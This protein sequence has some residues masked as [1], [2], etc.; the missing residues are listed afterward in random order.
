M[1]ESQQQRKGFLGTIQRIICR[2]V[3][4]ETPP[5]PTP[6]RDPLRSFEPGRVIILAEFPPELKL[7]PQEIV[8]RV[9]RRLDQVNLEQ[10]EEVRLPPER[11]VIL[12][13]PKLWLASVQGDV[14]A[15]R[16]DPARLFRFIDGL[17]QAIKKPPLETKPLGQDSEPQPPE[18]PPAPGG[19]P[20]QPGGGSG[21]QPPGPGPVAAARAITADADGFDL[22]A[23]SPNWFASGSKNIIGGGPGGWPSPATPPTNPNGPQPWE[24][25]L[26]PTLQPPEIGAIDVEVAI[27][28]TAPALADLL[29]AYATWVGS[30]HPRPLNP[31]LQSLLA[32]PSSGAFNVAD[33][34]GPSAALGPSGALDVV[35]LPTSMPSLLGDF[36]YPI[37]SHG[38][39][40]AG[41]IRLLAPKAKLRLIQALNNE[42]GGSITSIT[43]ALAAANH[44]GRTAPLVINCSFAMQIPRPN[45]IS[46]PPDM[47]GVPQATIDS[48]TQTLHDT[49]ALISQ[50]PDVVIVA[51]AGNT[52]IGGLHPLARFP[53][54]FE[55]VAGVAALKQ[56]LN[57]PP[58]PQLT[59]YSDQAD[60][61]PVE[62]FAA[63][64]GEVTGSNPS[65]ADAAKGVLGAF[66]ESWPI[67]GATPG[68]FS[69]QP[70][71]SGWARWAGTSFA[72]PMVS[73][74]LA[75]LF[76]EG[77]SPAN[78]VNIL[79]LASDDTS[80]RNAVPVKQ[81]S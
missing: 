39:F 42:A 49:F 78:A 7:T 62:G 71:S 64:G 14:P 31:L 55:A 11:V 60:D 65:I 58:A 56:D 12:R 67:P 23:A 74:I 2:L 33:R 1:S 70:N 27:L 30:N 61:Q 19:E 79:D 28:D 24:F 35:Y 51:A 15:A 63:F 8:D 21:D 38:L 50:L 66:I 75:N 16:Q 54:A 22:R 25:D 80:V 41:I 18:F 40:I 76:S 20:P 43:Q 32:D 72:A 34:Y 9:A 26:S 29:D 3:C 47:Q 48:M 77:R 69:T 45:D 13:G 73:A 36:P 81:H 52:G 59:D 17:H 4:D 68:S 37:P 53:A 46:I 57:T 5:P 10:Q 44:P 6:V